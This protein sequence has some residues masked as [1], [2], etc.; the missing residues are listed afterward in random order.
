LRRQ[1]GRPRNVANRLLAEYLASVFRSFGGRIVRRQTP[2][3][4]A[5]GGVLYVDD[6]PFSGKGGCSIAE[7]PRAPRSSCRT[8]SQTLAR[9]PCWSRRRLSFTRQQRDDRRLIP[10]ALLIE[11]D[12]DR[13]PGNEDADS[14]CDRPNPGTS[15]LRQPL[16]EPAFAVTFG[17]LRNDCD[18]CDELRGIP[19]Q[20]R[21]APK[22]DRTIS[23]T[24][25]ICSRS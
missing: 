23:R 18:G 11:Q 12:A 16:L 21:F 13:E 7:A 4:V 9:C 10:G 15:L 20:D 3:N 5:G 6:V 1:R 2:I 8:D 25:L 14:H 19:C 17:E 22:C 24:A